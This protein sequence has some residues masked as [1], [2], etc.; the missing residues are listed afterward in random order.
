[1]GD[2]VTIG[3]LQELRLAGYLTGKAGTQPI[4]VFWCEGA[5]FALDD[6]CPH[7]GFPL[8][9]GTVE[10]GL[11]TCHWHRA[12]F[13]VSSGGT[14]DPWADDVRAY[15][16]EIADGEVSVIVEAE[17]DRT[18][19]L[20]HRLEEGLEQGITLV[21]AKAVLRLLDTEV[22]P[23]DI[24]RVGADFGTRYRQAGWGAGLTVLTAMAN[25][26]PHLAPADHGLALVHGLDF[27]SRDT[28]GRPPRFPLLPLD[29]ALPADRL[30]QWYRRFIETRS[31]DAAERTLASAVSLV[32]AAAVA[33]IMFAAVTDHVFIDEGHTI[34]FT[35][36]AFE[37]L[38]HLGWDKAAEVLPTMVAQTAAA[39]RS[40]E[41]GS[42]RFPYDLAGMIDTATS[43]LP[44]RLAAAHDGFDHEAG[45]S[46]LAWLIL[47][48]DPAEVVSAV[49]EAIVN[50]A[51]PEECARAVAYAAA[52]RITRFHTQND[53]GDWDEVHHAFTAASA[54]HQAVQR[55]P[56]AELLRAVYHGALRVYLDRFLNV[57]AARLP[58][59]TPG[60][61]AVDLTD[62]QDCWDREGLVD[63]AGTIVYRYLCGGGDPSEAIAALGHA[64]LYEDAEFHWFQTYEAAVRQFHA[65][66]AGS[67]EGALILTGTARFLA[68]HTPTRRELSQVVRIAT[69]LGR[70]EALFEEA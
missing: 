54:L 18:G 61:D 43:A 14:L 51:T 22:S 17:P 68:A 46:K 55:A 33:E 36:K 53:H 42:W 60:G 20:L 3:T 62:L 57:P 35:N 37:V 9:R 41:R 30:G 6:R 10:S 59:A 69:R 70:G 7:M 32:D 11:L 5:P 52:L 40:E 67:E 23:R 49:D 4:C 24:V 2:R 38:E 19:H 21:I 1:M 25:L 28:R 12:R 27:V 44:E 63:E 31:A 13:D 45:A 47:S 56:T 48:D 64:L 39:T 65:W 8:H 26:L 58:G 34:D 15:P 50:G 66:P 29:G 16:V